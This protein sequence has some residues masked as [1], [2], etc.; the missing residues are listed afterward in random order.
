MKKASNINVT[1]HKEAIIDAGASILGSPNM[2]KSKSP[3]KSSKENIAAQIE[4]A[5]NLQKQLQKEIAHS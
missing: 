3:I 2:T 4:V 1:S 5:Q